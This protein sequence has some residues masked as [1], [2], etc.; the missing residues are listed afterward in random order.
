MVKL[1]RRADVQR[2]TEVLP[3]AAPNNA[4][5]Q[6]H[7]AVSLWIVTLGIVTACLFRAE[8]GI[9]MFLVSRPHPD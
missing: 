8:I 4:G 6:P 3:Q 5:S 2:F 1:G 7:S 9:I